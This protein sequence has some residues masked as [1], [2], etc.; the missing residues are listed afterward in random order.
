MRR[1]SIIEGEVHGFF[2]SCLFLALFFPLSCAAPPSWAGSVETRNGVEVI[3]NPGEPLLEDAQPHLSELW[4]VEG[5]NWVNPSL[6]HVEEGLVYV[7]DPRANQLHLISLAGEIQTSMGRPGGGPGE[8]RQLLDAFPVGDRIVVIDGGKGAVEYLDMDGNYLSS[9]HIQGQAWGGFPLEGETVLMKGE[10]LTDLL[11]ETRGDWVRVEEGKEPSAFTSLE[12][13]PLPEEQGVQ[14]SDLSGWWGGAARL[15]FTT[16]QLQI[17]DPSGGLSLEVRVDLPVEEVSEA[18]RDA[19]LADLRQRLEGRGMPPPFVEQSV[20]VSEERWRV[21]CRFG[22]LRF[23]PSGQI[24]AFLEQNPDNF[25]SGSAT[26]HFLSKDGVYLARVAFPTPWRDFAMDR[27]VVY[28]LIRDPLTD[29]VSLQAFR[30]DLPSTLLS[31]ASNLLEDARS[32]QAVS[33]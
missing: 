10:F 23:D 8:F 6:V 26:L 33:Q 18:E 25:G 17:F 5:P 32:D 3:S 29:V 27:G 12:M 21:K 2:L 24:A 16:P 22:P 1:S 14:C 19:A 7:V 9:S 4:G 28:A 15:R 30:L 11:E 13:E 20:V 31:D